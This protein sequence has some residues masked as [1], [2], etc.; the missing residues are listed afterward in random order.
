MEGIP[1][2]YLKSLELKDVILE[3]ADDLYAIYREDEVWA[4]KYVR[5]IYR[6]KSE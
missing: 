6:P 5:G 1:E 3:M 2:K 4:D